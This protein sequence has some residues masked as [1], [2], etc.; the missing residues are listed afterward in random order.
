MNSALEPVRVAVQA[1]DPFSRVG[2]L[3]T[4]NAR[5]DLVVVDDR[6]Q[7]QVVVASVDAVT[8]DVLSRLR[9]QVDLY[10]TP[11][12]LIT[13]NID[14]SDLLAA[15]ECRVVG[16]LSRAHATG[17]RLANV[18]LV[19]ASGGGVLPPDLLGGL[20]SHV[21]G[22]ARDVLGPL[23][24]GSSGLLPRE[25]DIL[26]LLADGLDTAEIA[27]RLSYSERTVKNV[28]FEMSCRLKLRNRSHAVAYA[29]RVGAI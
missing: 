9:R 13:N 28:L 27:E 16:V 18:L 8:S 10:G 3:T 11:T 24:L 17:S 12:V 25:V 26:R 2:L 15:I 5:A 14:Q 22:I 21:E 19:A 4:L 29:M 23:G 1:S 6:A 7:A 20:L